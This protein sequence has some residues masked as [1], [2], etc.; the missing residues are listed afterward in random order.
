MKCHRSSALRLAMVATLTGLLTAGCVHS[1]R[2]AVITEAV[3]SPDERT[4]SVTFTGDRIDGKVCTAVD[5]TEVTETA[6]RVT[7]GIHLA[8]V[9][10]GSP[11]E[12]VAGTG[13]EQTVQIHLTAPLGDRVVE[14]PDGQS[15]TIRRP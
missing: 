8:N 14:M 11:T 5:D 10:E 9:C 12:L 15:I 1:E 6:Q 4:V 2:L 3:I 7:I 13:V